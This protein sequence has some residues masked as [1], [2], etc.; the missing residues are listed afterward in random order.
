MHVTC[1]PNAKND[2]IPKDS[3]PFG[4]AP[5]LFQNDVGTQLVASTTK[6]SLSAETVEAFGDLCQWHLM[7]Y[8][9]KYSEEGGD[10]AAPPGSVKPSMQI[11]GE[12]TKAKWTEYLSQWKAEKK[13]AAAAR[14]R[15]IVL[16]RWRR[17]ARVS[18]AWE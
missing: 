4:Y 12:I 18:S 14:A 13:D 11:Q 15:G 3:A 8:F 5:M 9:Q 16:T 2:V 1:D 6:T 10:A 17:R 7:A